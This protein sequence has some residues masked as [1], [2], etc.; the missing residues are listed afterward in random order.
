LYLLGLFVGLPVIGSVA[1]MGS[2]ALATIQ[3]AG[4]LLGA[5]IGGLM[6]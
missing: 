4:L 5:A 2:C 3:V 6:G 1:D